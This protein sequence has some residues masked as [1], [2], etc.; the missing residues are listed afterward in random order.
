MDIAAALSDLLTFVETH[1]AYAGLVFGLMAF[2]E[3]LVVVGVLIP[4]T[5]V[6]MAAGA[7][8]GAGTLPFVDLWIGGALGAALG[9]TVS[10]WVGRRLGPHVHR[11]WPFSR[12]PET[13][14]AARAVFA[15]WGWAAILIGRF[16]GPLRASVPTVAGMSDM[17]PGVFQ[18]ANFG[19]A[20]LW[21]PVLIA[22]ASIGAVA[23][24]RFRGGDATTAGLLVAGLAAILIAAVWA[25]RRLLP[26]LMRRDGEP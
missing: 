26:R 25:W 21:I 6:M 7:L 8:V 9:D 18:A 13:L 4:A 17:R 24:D 3:S 5:G 1:R 16:I 10:F 15:R 22:P 2:G 12:H 23:W 20:I 14:A 11:L 19:S